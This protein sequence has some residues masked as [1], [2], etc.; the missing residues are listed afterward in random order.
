MVTITY[1]V[2]GIP[3]AS[4]SGALIFGAQAI[5]TTSPT[6]TVTLSN[7]AAAKAPLIAGTPTLTGPTPA[8][9]RSQRTAAHHR[10]PLAAAAR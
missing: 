1:Q 3:A 10:S 9:S 5:G 7:A 6:Q 8:T 4:I 2:P